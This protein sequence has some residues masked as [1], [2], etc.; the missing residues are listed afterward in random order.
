MMKFRSLNKPHLYLKQPVNGRLDAQLDYE[1]FRQHRIEVNRV[2]RWFG[3]A[4]LLVPPH[5]SS[6]P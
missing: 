3:M 6:C 5:L 2:R 1:A 4:P